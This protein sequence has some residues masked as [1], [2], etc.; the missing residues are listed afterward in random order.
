MAFTHLFDSV[1]MHQL[2]DV[3]IVIS[4]IEIDT[5]YDGTLDTTW[6]GSRVLHACVPSENLEDFVDAICK[7][8]AH[9]NQ[10]GSI[11]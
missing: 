8:S 1:R 10:M 7:H 5:D 2:I 3:T 9:V 4:V 6:P 11:D